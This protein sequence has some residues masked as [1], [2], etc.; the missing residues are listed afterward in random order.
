MCDC[1]TEPIQD[2]NV[3]WCTSCGS[4]HGEKV[5]YVSSYSNPQHFKFRYVY[6]RRKR[7]VKYLRSFNDPA[8]NANIEPIIQCFSILEM[9]WPTADTGTRKYFYSK[10]TVLRFIIDLFGIK[11]SATVNPL[12][13]AERTKTQV[14]CMKKA[15]AMSTFH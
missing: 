1:G 11:T 7:F 8:L 3:L 4:S 5:V 13:D 12:K 15:L 10:N 9:T 2:G 6:D 14:T